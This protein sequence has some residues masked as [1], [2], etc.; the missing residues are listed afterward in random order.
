LSENFSYFRSLKSETSKKFRVISP[1]DTFVLGGRLDTAPANPTV[2]SCTVNAVWI[3]AD[4]GSPKKYNKQYISSFG[5]IGLCLY[6]QALEVGESNETT[7]K[8]SVGLFQ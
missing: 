8:K 3:A 2:L 1:S 4:T 5:I 6:Q 7:A